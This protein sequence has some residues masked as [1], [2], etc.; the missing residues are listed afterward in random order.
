MGTQGRGFFSA[1]SDKSRPVRSWYR[2]SSFSQ[3]HAIPDK[4]WECLC[5]RRR[6]QN[7]REQ[8]TSVH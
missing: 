1:C 2:R 8:G 5:R 3:S 4:E 7:D 6:I